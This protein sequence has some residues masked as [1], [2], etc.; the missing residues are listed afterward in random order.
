MNDTISKDPDLIA[1]AL[2]AANRVRTTGT[3]AAQSLTF[4]P[5][6]VAEQEFNNIADRRFVKDP[7]ASLWETASKH[8]SPQGELVGYL[9]ET[10][11]RLSAQAWWYSLNNLAYLREAIEAQDRAKTLSTAARLQVASRLRGEVANEL[12]PDLIQGTLHRN[13]A[14]IEDTL[15]A[16]EE[17]MDSLKLSK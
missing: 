17:L 10:E 3:P 15:A 1:E 9:T 4:D 11:Y 5:K 16:F 2:E 14:S 6:T 12:T 8:V 7:F 13:T